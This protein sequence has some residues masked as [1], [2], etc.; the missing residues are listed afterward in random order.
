MHSVSRILLAAASFYAAAIPAFASESFDRQA[1]VSRVA[2]FLEEMYVD[3]KIGRELA[4]HLRR[5]QK[6]GAFDSCSAPAA[7]A[8]AVTRAMREVAD[9][10]HLYL[11]YGL[12]TGGM[13]AAVRIDH[14]ASAPGAAGDAPHGGARRVVVSPQDS[15]PPGAERG[16]AR[17]GVARVE[18]LEGNVGYLA[19]SGFFPGDRQRDAVASAMNVLEDTN[20][21]VIDVA[22]C[23]GGTPAA[24][25]FLESY[26]F[27]PDGRE[28]MS[29]YDRP[30]DRTDHEY[31]LKEV[32]GKRRPDVPLYIVTSAATG[33]ACEA[34]AYTLQKHGRATVVG[35]RTAGAGYNNVLMPAG[36][37][38]TAS[39]SV[40]R[41]IHPKTGRGWE[42]MGVEPDVPAAAPM[43]TL[44]AHREALQALLA[45]APTEKRRSVEW[46]LEGV[47]AKEK[48][49]R[50]SP[51]ALESFS[52]HYG[53][54]E[55]TVSEGSL[56]FRSAGGR[57][58]GPLLP[59][60]GGSF[61][62]GEELRISFERGSG[63]TISAMSVQRPDGIVERFAR[64][65]SAPS[66]EAPCAVA[67][68]GNLP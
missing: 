7:L 1:V 21:L 59:I 19:L 42:K 35:E 51:A 20:A 39:V 62:S 46:A 45:R 27:P 8:D 54:R 16:P 9:D 50:E 29:R 56:Y 6:D 52:G 13:G 38:F 31:T 44:A 36:D 28:M 41:P 3:P 17:S 64:I 12:D 34:F 60:G 15:A 57:T 67:E 5:R 18:R 66:A 65:A 26:F 58:Y 24:V 25:L 22:K 68:K 10:K 33:S 4:E 49:V 30:M 47:R 55:I 11:R 23:P 43:G 61:L 37:G 2:G 63:G 40:A 53:A 48:P 14:S 32:P